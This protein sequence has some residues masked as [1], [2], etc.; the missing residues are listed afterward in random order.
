MS[1]YL[2]H[3]HFILQASA[4]KAPY[5]TFSL[6]FV[7]EQCWVYCSMEAQRACHLIEFCWPKHTMQN[8]YQH[9]T[10]SRLSYI[11]LNLM[12]GSGTTQWSSN[13]I[14]FRAR[15]QRASR[16]PGGRL[17]KQDGL[18]D[19]PYT[20][21]HMLLARNRN[22]SEYLRNESGKNSDVYI[23]CLIG[24]WSGQMAD[25]EFQLYCPWRS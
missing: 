20:T 25:S 18:N 11:L 5:K 3:A 21:D 14:F 17:Y 24:I 13:W 4:L 8:T 19:T 9:M 1:A 16:E 15:Y 10:R 12:S 6:S 2:T 22:G 23:L 7:A